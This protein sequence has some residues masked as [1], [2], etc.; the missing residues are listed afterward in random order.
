MDFR[1]LILRAILT[2]FIITTIFIWVGV[3]FILAESESSDTQNI[4]NEDDVSDILQGFSERSQ[5]KPVI[6]IGDDSYYPPY[7]FLDKSGNPAGYNVELARAAGAAMGYDVIIR[8]NSWD[9][10]RQALE[11]GEIDAIAGMFYSE[12]RAELY[13]FTTRHSTT[14]GAIFAARGYEISKIE[15]LAGQR[16]AVQSADIVEEILTELNRDLELDMELIKTASVREALNLVESGVCNYAGL[17]K[18]PALYEIDNSDLKNVDDQQIDFFSNDYCMAVAKDNEDLAAILN[19]GLQIIKANGTYQKIYDRW[20]GVYD[21]LNIDHLLDQYKLIPIAAAAILTIVAIFGLILQAI[22]RKKT[23]ELV[24][25]NADLMDKQEQLEY[26]SNHDVL[27]GLYNRRYFESLIRSLPEK[28]K[29]PLCVIVGDVNDLKT[30]NDQH[31]HQAGDQLLVKAA[32]IMQNYSAGS[33]VI[34]RIGGDEFVIIMTETRP[35]EAEALIRKIRTAAALEQNSP[36]EI[37]ISFGISCISDLNTD[38][39]EAF[40]QA[41]NEMYANKILEKNKYNRV[42]SQD[43]Q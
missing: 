17:L 22:I 12:Q 39:M 28:G 35:D 20:L 14:S 30:T 19:G 27:T 3:P 31:G 13:N 25:I 43:N 36:V 5:S 33:D 21:P 10:T 4:N 11:S 16:V 29:T 24:R 9:K 23:N 32:Q 42:L 34:C 37:S 8:L 7:S 6:I 18:L 1:K 38:I 26:I 2:A 15:E 41:E 40:K